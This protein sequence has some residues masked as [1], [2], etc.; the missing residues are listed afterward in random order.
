MKWNVLT[1]ETSRFL[2]QTYLLSIS[3]IYFFS[4]PFNLQVFFVFV[5]REAKT[6][7]DDTAW[8]MVS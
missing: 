1:N 7:E 3:N 2:H 4:L 8:D 5:E 6:D